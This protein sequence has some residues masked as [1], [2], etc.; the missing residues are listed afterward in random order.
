MEKFYMML[1]YALTGLVLMGISIPMIQRK[2][3]PNPWYGLRTPKTL[4]SP[5]IWYPANE[6]CGV[7][8]MLAGGVMA[9]ASLVLLF[10][11]FLSRDS[12]AFAQ[13]AVVMIS[14]IFA[15]VKSFQYVKKL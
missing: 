6:Y 9:V 10:V 7:M 14:L 1:G 8:L 4:S 3:R 5:N 11:P 13:L 15:V 12:Y 2:V